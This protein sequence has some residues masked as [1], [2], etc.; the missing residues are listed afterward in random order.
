MQVGTLYICFPPIEEREAFS[1]GPASA[2]LVNSP[3]PELYG[4]VCRG[5]W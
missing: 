1:T 5:A 2:V 4:P 3:S